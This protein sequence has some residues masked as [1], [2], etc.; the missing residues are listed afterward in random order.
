MLSRHF[1]AAVALFIFLAA[2]ARAGIITAD[3]DCRGC[4]RRLILGK[5]AHYFIGIA[6]LPEQAWP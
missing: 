2:A 4:M 6:A 5:N 1:A 3:F